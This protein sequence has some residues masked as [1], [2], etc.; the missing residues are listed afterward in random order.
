MEWVALVVIVLALAWWVVQGETGPGSRG[1][2][3][4]PSGFAS[5]EEDQR[6][7]PVS[8]PRSNDEHQRQAV[9]PEPRP[10]DEGPQPTVA[11]EPRSPEE[12]PQPAVVPGTDETP[13]DDF[14]SVARE[15]GWFVDPVPQ[16]LVEAAED[17][18]ASNKTS[19]VPLRNTGEP[20]DKDEKRALGVNV[21]AKLGRD[22]VN[23]LSDAGRAECPLRAIE[24]CLQRTRQRRAQKRDSQ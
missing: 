15:S 24:T 17:W 4:I 11:P 13:P 1:R 3:S 20:L 23:A 10:T 12:G 9:A 22:Y 6:E 14:A 2:R 19:V 16:W 7:A 21:N 5:T 18:L 8:E